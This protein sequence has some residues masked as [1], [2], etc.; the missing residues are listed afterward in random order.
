[1]RRR[2]VAFGTTMHSPRDRSAEVYAEA[3]RSLP[4]ERKLQVSAELR[5]LAWELKS[6]VIRREH[7]EWPEERVQGRVAEIFLRA[8]S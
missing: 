3:V 7:P 1:M 2:G 6:S 8:G 4:L 5:R